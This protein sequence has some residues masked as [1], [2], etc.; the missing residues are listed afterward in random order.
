MTAPA[1]TLG[2]AGFC[3]RVEAS[4]PADLAWLLEFLGPAFEER[5]DAAA[6]H[7]VT[8][9]TSLDSFKELESLGPHASA[10]SVGCFALDARMATCARWNAPGGE[11]VVFD[12]AMRAFYSKEG[13]DRTRI[14][15][16]PANRAAR[17]GLF[18]VV[19]EIVT[20][21]V[22][23]G[24]RLLVHGAALAWKGQGYVIAGAKEAGKTTLLLHLLSRADGAFVANDRVMIRA[25]R[26]PVA[27]RGMPTIVNVRVSSLA[28]LPHLEAIFCERNYHHHFL[29]DEEGRPTAASAAGQSGSWSITPA[30]LVD[31]LGSDRVSEVPMGGLIFPT[32]TNLPGGMRLDRL[33]RRAAVER[34]RDSLFR[35]GETSLVGEF[36]ADDDVSVSSASRDDGCREITGRVP[37]F[38]CALGLDV[39]DDP[40]SAGRM[41]AAVGN[42]PHHVREGAV[43]D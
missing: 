10:R 17:V 38:D 32:R 26:D 39:Y 16:E 28:R 33:S 25:D 37:C 30:Q 12:Q 24:D 27:V 15:A 40:E 22:L 34:L 4:D 42:R 41:L 43:E 23:S 35:A 14:V 29:L 1:I 31:I 7:Q 18:R 5:P 36:F 21:R 13:P 19:R 3:V 2:Y 20:A 9:E 6:G 11:D 8:L